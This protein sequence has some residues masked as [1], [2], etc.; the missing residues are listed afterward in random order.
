MKKE[1][2]IKHI[3]S[4]I[5]SKEEQNR[6][7]GW[8]LDESQLGGIVYKELEQKYKQFFETD[9]E[10]VKAFFEL[11]TIKFSDQKEAVNLL[12]LPCLQAVDLS[13]NKIKKIQMSSLPQ[14]KILEAQQGL[15]E[16]VELNN[17]PSLE[18]L[19]LSVLFLK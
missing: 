12:G 1:V 7:L 5:F 13:E 6:K 17:L 9:I 15:L 18:T 11:N 16:S 2:Q 10:D 8:Q 19:W 14:L 3:K 4:L